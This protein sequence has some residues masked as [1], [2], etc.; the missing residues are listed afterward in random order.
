M[1]GF[2]FFIFLILLMSFSCGTNPQKE[3]KTSKSAVD[4]SS[5]KINGLSFVAASQP[6]D[7]TELE[8]LVKTHANHLAVMPFGFLSSLK[9]TDVKFDHPRQ[10]WGERTDGCRE[11]VKQCH[12]RGF[13]IM[14]KPQIWIGGGE[15]TG[16]IEMETEENWQK[17]EENYTKFILNFAQIAEDEKVDIFCIGTELGKFVS[18][19]PT[20][21]SGLIRKVREIYHGKLTYAENWDCFDK[22]GFLKELDYVGVDAYFPL[23]SEKSPS[24]AEIRAGWQS[25]LQTMEACSKAAGKPILFTECGYRSIDYAGFKPWDFDKKNA[26][27][28]QELQDRLIWI[29]FEL[30]EKDWMAGGFIWKWFPYHNSAGG[31]KD[32]QFS[33][34]NKLAEKSIVAF[35]KEGK[36]N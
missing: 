18:A 32:D 28:N 1:R 7:K 26:E 29:M 19:R 11:T 36:I 17:L 3:T 13:K 9:S 33:P 24:E 8:V 22:P 30:W 10:W 35:F 16:F 12:E 25:H 5:V 2:Y 34:Q 23:S 31:P 21:W 15:F 27:V 6:F 4:G 20:Y 14:M